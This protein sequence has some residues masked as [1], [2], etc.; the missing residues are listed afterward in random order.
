VRRLICWEARP[1]GIDEPATSSAVE[2]TFLQLAGAPE[3]AIVG[4]EK[5][6]TV[7]PTVRRL[8]ADSA[9]LPL[10]AVEILNA[11]RL[12]PHNPHA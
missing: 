6:E 5:G 10:L 7:Q 2:R 11:I 9:G 4:I 12:A 1:Y 3:V 8:Q